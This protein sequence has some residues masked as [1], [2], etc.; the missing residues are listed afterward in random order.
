VLD[1]APQ[2]ADALVTTLAILGQR[3]EHDGLD[4]VVDGATRAAQAPRGFA[5][6]PVLGD[7]GFA[8]RRRGRFGDVPS[9]SASGAVT[10]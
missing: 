10:G 6:D 4:L 2:F 9:T 7:P 1:V 5:G 3:F 8:R